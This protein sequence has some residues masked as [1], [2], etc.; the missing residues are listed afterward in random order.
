[1]LGSARS[2]QDAKVESNKGNLLQKNFFNVYLFL[3]ERERQSMSWGGQRE[4]E[5]QNPNQAPGSKLSG[6]P[7]AGLELPSYEIMI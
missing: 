1:M 3:K 7:D 2:K 4:R 6:P 5:T